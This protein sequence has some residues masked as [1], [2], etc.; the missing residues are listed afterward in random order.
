M[1]LTI[2]K[3]A[4]SAIRRKKADSNT[5]IGL[6]SITLGSIKPGKR[7]WTGIA[8]DSKGYFCLFH[9]FTLLNFFPETIESSPREYVS[10]SILSTNFKIYTIVLRR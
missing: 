10:C 2:T 6:N 9:N 8:Y 7:E 1:T 4:N 5:I 3:R